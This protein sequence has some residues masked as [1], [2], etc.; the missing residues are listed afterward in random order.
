MEFRRVLFRSGV[1][2][3]RRPRVEAKAFALDYVR[4]PADASVRLAD[5][6]VAAREPQVHARAQP[7]EAAAHDDDPLSFVTA[8]TLKA[9]RQNF[10]E[11]KRTRP[12][13]PDEVGERDA[14]VL[15]RR[16]H[17]KLLSERHALAP[18]DA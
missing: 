17:P 12:D 11:V 9:R 5:E 10:V 8:Q 4:A 16:Q 2:Q 13:S 7:A 15:A 3:E 18:A 6:N 1:V 14:P